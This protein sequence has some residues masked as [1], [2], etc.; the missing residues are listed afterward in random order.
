[1]LIGSIVGLSDLGNHKID[2]AAGWPAATS[3]VPLVQWPMRAW[4][5]LLDSRQQR[6]ICSEFG[7]TTRY[8]M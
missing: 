3:Q 2:F 4:G 8:L 5:E 6:L 1:L 7:F